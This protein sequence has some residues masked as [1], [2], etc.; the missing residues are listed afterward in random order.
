MKPGWTAVGYMELDVRIL[1]RIG[2][3]RQ[4]DSGVLRVEVPEGCTAEALLQRLEVS[5]DR[6]IVVLVNGRRCSRFTRLR[7]DDRVALMTPVAGG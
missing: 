2:E 7:H 4:L 6:A 3:Q 5:S 1:T